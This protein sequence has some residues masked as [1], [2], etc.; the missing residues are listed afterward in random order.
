MQEFSAK[1]DALFACL[2][3]ASKELKG[4]ALDQS[5]SKPYTVNAL[6]RANNSR[7]GNTQQVMNY[8]QGRS[9]EVGNEP[10]D[11]KLRRLR[12]KESIFKKPE[13]PIARCL[14]PRKTP[15]YQM[16]PHKWKKYSLSDV[17]ISDQTNSAAALSFLREMD[18]QRETEADDVD[19]EA[20]GGHKIEF[21]KKSKLNRNL[22]Q[23]KQDE[24]EDVELDKPQLRGSKLIMPEYVIG[25]KPARKSK[26]QQST[27]QSRAAGKLQ[28]S[29]LEEVEETDE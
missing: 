28:L 1:R 3:D 26:N 21:K 17:D 20:G 18:A 23:L 25:Q 22:K 24:V 7:H 6:E 11:E 16:N 2:D 10:E 5:R 8:R 15:D 29:H 14:K 9:V 4:T 19:I 27:R 13:L 12:G